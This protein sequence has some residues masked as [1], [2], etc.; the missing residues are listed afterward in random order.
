[1]SSYIQQLAVE[2]EGDKSD[3]DSK[4]DDEEEDDLNLNS[5]D[6]E[7]EFAELFLNRFLIGSESIFMD[8]IDLRLMLKAL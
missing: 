7:E 4:K 3:T 8:K 2:D 5:E 6:A 1:M